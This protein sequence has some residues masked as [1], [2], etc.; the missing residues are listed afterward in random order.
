MDVCFVM[1][2]T[3]SM[4]SYINTTKERLRSF[5]FALSKAEI[6]PQ[7]AYGVVAYRDHPP[8]DATYVTQVFE[9]SEDISKTQSVLNSLSAK[10]GGDEPEAVLDGIHDAISKLKWRKQA[11]K[12][13]ILVG[14]APPH[15]V[16]GS[17]DAFP[18]GCPAG[19]TIETVTKQA[20]NLGISIYSVGVVNNDITRR[21]FSNIAK[22]TGGEFVSLDSV[23]GLIDRILDGMKIEFG[24]ITDD[25]NIFDY[26]MRGATVDEIAQLAG[27]TKHE[28]DQIVAR[29]NTKGAIPVNLIAEGFLPTSWNNFGK[30]YQITDNLPTTPDDISGG[31]E[32]SIRVY[33]KIHITVDYPTKMSVI[34]EVPNDVPVE[35]L[36]LA[37]MKKLGLPLAE[38]YFLVHDSHPLP[39]GASLAS[40]GIKDGDSIKID[41]QQT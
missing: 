12:I 19:Y 10:G 4:S 33:I 5:A 22:P 25:I 23:E 13:I 31:E 11:Q 30:V 20:V 21:A 14:D 40:M 15:G 24:K 7:V 17:G 41:R 39:S 16:G 18:K 36:V 9:F 27:K 2:T 37:L 6:N 1:D 29:L 8:Q 35:K 32:L 34:V 38:K 28:V 26:L 3:G